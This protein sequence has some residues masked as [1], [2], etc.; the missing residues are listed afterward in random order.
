[1]AFP[2]GY[3]ALFGFADGGE[4]LKYAEYM[5]RVFLLCGIPLEI[6]KFSVGYYPSVNRNFPAVLTVLLRDALL[7]IPLTLLFMTPYGLLGYSV[8]H[9]VTEVLTIAIV[10]CA[11]LIYNAAKKQTK[12]IFMLFE[13][14]FSSLDEFDAGLYSK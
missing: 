10:Y 7:V 1:M 13:S 8:A 9:V 11:V 3:A 6:N 5:I 2:G 4:N 12:G 14:D